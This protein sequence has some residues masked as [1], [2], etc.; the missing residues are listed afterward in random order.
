MIKKLPKHIGYEKFYDGIWFHQH[1]PKESNQDGP[2]TCMFK[3]AQEQD[4]PHKFFVTKDH[5]KF[6]RQYASYIDIDTFYVNCLSKIEDGKRF[7]Y[8]IIPDD[9]PVPAYFDLEWETDKYN[10]TGKDAIAYFIW[11][12]RRAFK[13]K[14]G[15]K[16]TDILFD[17]NLTLLEDVLKHTRVTSACGMK[18]ID[19]TPKNYSSYHLILRC[20]NSCRDVLFANRE[21]QQKFIGYLKKRLENPKNGEKRTSYIGLKITDLSVYSKNR[22]M[23]LPTCSKANDPMRMLIPQNWHNHDICEHSDEDLLK[24][25]IF[26]NFI[27]YKRPEQIILPLL[28][29]TPKINVLK[30]KRNT[31]SSDYEPKNKKVRTEYTKDVTC[32][33]IC[34]RSN[35]FV[36]EAI[37]Y[38]LSVSENKGIN[39]EFGEC[40]KHIGSEDQYTILTFKYQ[41]NSKKWKK[42][43]EYVCPFGGHHAW[44]GPYAYFCTHGNLMLNCSGTT[45]EKSKKPM[46]LILS[47]DDQSPGNLR[48]S[49]VELR[50]CSRAQCN[51][52]LY[53]LSSS[54][55]V[56]KYACIEEIPVSTGVSE[57]ESFPF[58]GKDLV[59]NLLNSSEVVTAAS[60]FTRLYAPTFKLQRI[61]FCTLLREWYI[62]TGIFWKKVHQNT[63]MNLMC[64]HVSA[65]Y[66]MAASLNDF[67]KHEEKLLKAASSVE[68][69]HM[70]S[71]LSKCESE[72]RLGVF[73]FS[74]KLDS[75]VLF[76]AFN[77][78]ILSFYEKHKSKPFLKHHPK[79]NISIINEYNF[80]D[81]DKDDEI[82]YELL[83]KTFSS[84]ND[85]RIELVQMLFGLWLTGVITEKFFVIL[86]SPQPDSAKTTLMDIFMECL[87]K[88]ATIMDKSIVVSKPT[89]FFN[90]A[91]PGVVALKN[92]RLAV[93]SETSCDFVLDD[94]AVKTHVCGDKIKGRGLYQDFIEF[95]PTH[96]PVIVTNKLPKFKTTDISLWKKLIVI[97]FDCEFVDNPKKPNQYKRDPTYRERAMKKIPAFT[98]WGYKGFVKYNERGRKLPE[99]PRIVEEITDNYRHNNKDDIDTFLDEK[100]TK[101]DRGG[102]TSEE[103]FNA[104]KNWYFNANQND[105]NLTKTKFGSELTSKGFPSKIGRRKSST[106]TERLYPFLIKE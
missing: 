97:P 96:K 72:G 25:T 11:I 84:R 88:H 38:V 89:N 1:G 44:R 66:R 49:G 45:C 21:E 34:T 63:I 17:S 70:F 104:F 19:G 73:N 83:E 82:V 65:Q 47:N 62:W 52:G 16:Y 90:G 69:G 23:R 92:K 10:F 67:E 56:C 48:A 8:E 29:S 91:T 55:P 76:L 43:H 74:E 28:E 37:S 40:K 26:E 15:K 80:A 20:I 5:P 12:Y 22:N 98:Y 32:M 61:K 85:P 99:I 31:S 57:F 51:P 103:L 18:E 54:Y 78:G 53:A 95:R 4:P 71:V 86:Y 75:D 94:G 64:T 41:N 102:S 3:F 50:K 93:L 106:H 6:R 59:W 36:E 14:Y 27:N 105:P 81:A 68:S 79:Y 77:D 24:Q 39:L 58:V 46:M 87:G 13:E 42:T 101:T 33:E 35:R 7:F 30:R 2:Q 100:C 60:I 9:T